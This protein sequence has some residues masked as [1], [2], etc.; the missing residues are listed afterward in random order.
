MLV[1]NLMA[2]L[3]DWAPPMMVAD[4]YTQGLASIQSIGTS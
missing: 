1:I 4:I 3:S 2:V